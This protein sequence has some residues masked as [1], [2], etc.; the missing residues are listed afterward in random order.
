MKKVIR[1]GT[2][3]KS[4]IRSE[5]LSA[6]QAGSDDLN[7]RVALIQALIPLG[8]KEVHDE[9]QD[10]VRS[11]VGE[12][13]SRQSPGVGRWG[14]NPG[15][16][17]LG[18][19]KVLIEVPRV[20]NAN[21]GCEIPLQSYQALQNPRVID[22]A[23][24]ARLINGISCRKYEEAAL[25]IPETF[26]IK[27]NS[28]S[29]RFIRATSRQLKKLMERDLSQKDIVAIFIDGK[30][31]ADLEVVIA[32]GITIEGEKLILGFVETSTEN[33]RV[34]KE[35]LS[36]LVQRG[37]KTEEEILFIIDG[38]KGIRKAITD[39]IGAGAWVQRCQWHKRENVVSYLDK[40][41]QNEFRGKLQAAYEKPTYD[42]AKQQLMNIRQELKQLNVSAVAS[43]DEGME[44]T[45]TLHRLGIFSELGKSFK[46]TNCI[47]S[48]NSMVGRYTGRVTSWKNSDQ[49]QRWVASA[50]LEI[51]P[52]I[53]RVKGDRLLKKT[54]LA[55]KQPAVCEAKAA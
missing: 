30:S 20:R 7:G 17:Y 39:V 51:E 8:L 6:M 31:L 21:E 4:K 50:L 5:T 16:V 37:L 22:H 49:R 19:Q 46:T 43:L 10:E 3:S 48:L 12:K 18:D 33:A 1:F 34:C 14:K 40:K 26:G 29:R 25:T 38:A 11:L 15:S 42:A 53:R 52:C 28:V 41:H 35:F 13:H 36:G 55:M 24:F 32:L 27:R 44:E 23:V 2:G 45:L 54:R 9:L 47:E